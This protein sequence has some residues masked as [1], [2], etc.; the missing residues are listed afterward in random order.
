[1][2]QHSIKTE[3]ESSQVVKEVTTLDARYKK[4]NA[5]E[6]NNERKRLLDLLSNRN[7]N[8]EQR[9]QIRRLLSKLSSIC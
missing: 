4:M 2:E 5:T 8:D 7:T 1:M 3:T 9:H 6:L